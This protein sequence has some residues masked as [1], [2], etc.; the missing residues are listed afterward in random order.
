MQRPAGVYHLNE[1]GE[2]VYYDDAQREREIGALQAS[3][4]TYC[5]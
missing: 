3:V 4:K 5:D 1:K 2:K